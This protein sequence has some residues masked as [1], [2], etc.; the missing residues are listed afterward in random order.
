MVVSLLVGA[1]GAAKRENRAVWSVSKPTSGM[2][3]SPT[4]ASVEIGA[5]A[6]T[7]LAR[8]GSLTSRTNRAP[9]RPA[10]R[11]TRMKNATGGSGGMSVRTSHEHQGN[12]RHPKTG[13]SECCG[14]RRRSGLRDQIGQRNDFN[15]RHGSTADLFLNHSVAVGN[16]A[17][18]ATDIRIR[19]N[20]HRLT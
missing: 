16:E 8:K 11:S 7:V 14:L 5:D 17:I 19:P 1:L 6:R 2:S 18:H 20:P 10:L 15:L 3:R 4:K 12:L 9:L 13:S